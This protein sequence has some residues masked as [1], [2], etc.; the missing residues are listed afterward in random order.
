MVA[1]LMKQRCA[2]VWHIATYE[3][4]SQNWELR[5]P[6]RQRTD[7][8]RKKIAVEKRR[9]FSSGVPA[10]GCEKKKRGLK[11]KS[12]AGHSREKFVPGEGRHTRAPLPYPL[13]KQW[14]LRH[15]DFIFNGGGNGRNVAQRA[16]KATVAHYFPRIGAAHESTPSL[17]KWMCFFRMKQ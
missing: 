13:P 14:L 1:I 5:L 15:F 4:I 2:S 7:N 17:S 8:G 9:S 16:K 6:H 10:S 12:I 3:N 11:K